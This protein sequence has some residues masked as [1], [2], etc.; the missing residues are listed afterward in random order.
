MRIGIAFDLKD[1]AADAA[2]RPDDWQ[3]EFDSPVTIRAIADAIRQ[4]GHEPVELGNGRGLVEKLLRD[5]PD[6]VFNIAEGHGTSR[7]REARV[8]AVCELLGVP[9]TG[10][11]PLTLAVALDKDCARRLAEAHGVRVPWGRLIPPTGPLPDDVPSYPVILKPAW[12]G[13]SKG[14]RARCLVERAEDL[15]EVVAGL[16][17]DY[18]QPL[19]LEE[20][21]A[22]EEVTVGVVGNDPPRVLGALRVVPTVPTERFVYSLEVKRDWERQV[23]YECPPALPAEQLEQLHNAALAAYAALGCRDVAR[24]DFRLRAGLPYFI[25]ANPLPGLNPESS[26]LV[27]I[28]RFLGQDHAALLHLILHAAFHRVGLPNC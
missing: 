16:R 1:H 24:I 17:R 9:Y 7:S 11:D 2:G 8:P 5:P 23:R 10:S 22:G 4:L 15:E 28:A 18:G 20:F 27:F 14:I 6:L 12:E 3:E 21:A 26:D 19:V 13:S 25:E